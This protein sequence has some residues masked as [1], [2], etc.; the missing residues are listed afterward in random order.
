MTDSHRLAARNRDH[1]VP[2][3][4]PLFTRSTGGVSWHTLV[5]W[6]WGKVRPMAEVAYAQASRVFPG[7]PPVRAVDGLSPSRSTGERPRA[8][9]MGWAASSVASCWMNPASRNSP[10]PSA[11]TRSTDSSAMTLLFTIEFST[12]CTSE[13]ITE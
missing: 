10:F 11:T 3:R 2:I 13:S 6:C 7:P 8:Q 9:R 4:Y 12:A 5:T 1:F